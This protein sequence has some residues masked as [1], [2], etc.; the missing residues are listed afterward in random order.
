MVQ[1]FVFCF[2]VAVILQVSST[3]IARNGMYG[4]LFQG[5]IMLTPRQQQILDL[6]RQGI[7]SST[8]ML[9]PENYWPKDSRGFVIV[10]Y[11]ILPAFSELHK[12]VK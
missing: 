2:L 3:P 6:S 10:P 4:N 7:Q 5:D 9:T 12:L 8:G 11:V 1:K